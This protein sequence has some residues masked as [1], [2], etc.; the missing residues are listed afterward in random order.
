ML[1][2]IINNSF[3]FYFTQ[4]YWRDEVYSILISERPILWF[5][6]VMNLE[7][8]VYYSLLHFWMKIFGNSEIATRSLS[9]LF[10]LLST[11]IIV[12][13]SE[14]HFKDK[15]IQLILP[16]SFFFNPM[17]IYYAFEVR[18][19]GV[20]LFMATLSLYAYIEKKWLLF[21]VASI[22]GFYTHTYYI[23]LF[24]S[25]GVHFIYFNLLKKI[26]LKEFR[27]KII[28]I[29]IK[30]FLFI[31][32]SYI[33]WLINVVSKSGQFK[34][35]WY[36]PVDLQLIKSVLGNMFI[37]YEGTPWF[38]WK[39]TFYLS[40][41]LLVFIFLSLK[42]KK[43]RHITSLLSLVIFIPLII[44]IGVSF[45]KPLFV[46]RYLIPVTIAE[47]MIIYYAVD[48]INKVYIRRFIAVFI[49]VL[50]F[51]FNLWYPK[52]HAK[53]P[54]RDTVNEIK[55]IKKPTDLY[56]AASS[57]NFFEIFLYSN[58]RNKVFLYNPNN[59]AFPWYVGKAV[60]SDSSMAS[61]IP[62]YPIRAFLINTDGTYNIVYR[63]K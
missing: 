40:L 20:Y 38:L 8:P 54:I 43:T 28:L 3:L 5:L 26:S 2:F 52:Q 47:V 22:L 36:F 16:F 13:W 39:Y 31:T 15:W 17:I 9:L 63:I 58:D 29:P 23:F 10:I 42:N 37:G 60:F 21:T 32:L 46:N 56:Y 30:A 7:P 57:L 55:A 53:T 34:Q 35:S 51:M 18:A 59:S 45:K 49:L 61:D 62:T 50:S 41:V 4:S 44:V 33:P 11:I 27:K 19:Y 12:Y 6:S 48:S 1:N 14:K 25:Q 24:I